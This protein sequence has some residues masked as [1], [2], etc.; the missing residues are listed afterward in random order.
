M[1][2]LERNYVSIY[3]A[4]SDVYVKIFLNA[5]STL[6]SK[7]SAETSIICKGKDSN[8]MVEKPESYHL[9]QILKVH[10]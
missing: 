9:N 6:V 7:Y 5:G 1:N 10:Q 3:F 8:F 4:S 2:P